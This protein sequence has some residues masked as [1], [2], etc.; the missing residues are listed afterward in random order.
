MAP[1]TFVAEPGRITAITG[2]S[3][4]G[5]STLLA[6]LEGFLAPTTGSINVGVVDVRELDRDAWLANLAVMQQDPVLLGPTI[7]DDIRLGRPDV[8]LAA[9]IQA[10]RSVG[11]DA[12]EL[13][14]GAATPVGDVRSDVS[15][16]QRRRISLARVLLSPA[17]IIL[18]DEPTAGLDEAGE[19]IAI[20]VIRRLAQ[21]GSVVIVVAHRPALIAAADTVIALEPVQV[22]A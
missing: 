18:L 1:V 3:G 9:V 12:D 19:T 17:P 7:G 14:L 4:C 2:P 13:V 6:V 22:T 15:A 21:T 8:P 10:L 5:K 16:G 20:E 11:L